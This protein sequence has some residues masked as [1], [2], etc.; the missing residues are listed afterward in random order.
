M[1]DNAD[2]EKVD[3]RAHEKVRA[4][5]ANETRATETKVAVYRLGY[6]QGY[7]AAVTGMH[8]HLQTL[9]IP[10]FLPPP[11]PAPEPVKPTGKWMP[12]PELD[13]GHPMATTAWVNRRIKDEM[14]NGGLARRI[15]ELEAKMV[16]R[17]ENAVR[18]HAEKDARISELEQKWRARME[19]LADLK[20][21][22]GLVWS[23]HKMLQDLFNAALVRIEARATVDASGSVH[24]SQFVG[25]AADR[26]ARTAPHPVPLPRAP[27]SVGPSGLEPLRH[28][29]ECSKA[30]EL[31]SACPECTPQTKLDEWGALVHNQDLMGGIECHRYYTVDPDT[32]EEPCEVCGR[33]QRKHWGTR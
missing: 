2:N 6:E 33:D 4:G 32:A 19:E 26:F 22:L 29:S 1:I 10:A 31:T 24:R 9:T 8:E 18:F 23:N 28:S 7:S 20:R 17:T 16:E 15:S 30:G 12:S 14:Q 3:W 5:I 27:L 25:A 21:D 11:T 13:Q